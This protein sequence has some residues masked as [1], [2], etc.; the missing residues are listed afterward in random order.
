MDLIGNFSNEIFMKI[1]DDLQKTINRYEKYPDEIKYL[2]LI[3]KIFILIAFSKNGAMIWAQEEIKK[4]KNLPLSEE[5]KTE[6]SKQILLKVDKIS[7]T[8]DLVK[9]QL[10]GLENFI[11][12]ETKSSLT[13]ME[14]KLDEVLLGPYY[15]AGIEMMNNAMKDFDINK[16]GEKKHSPPLRDYD[17][18]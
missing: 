16:S 1:I 18:K 17:F 7:E 11:Q 3:D 9:N 12:S 13:H 15:A 14:K 4:V 10:N 2:M 5:E 8:I 6:Q